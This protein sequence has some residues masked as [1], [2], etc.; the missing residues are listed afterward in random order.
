[1]NV[2]DTSDPACAAENASAV[3]ARIFATGNHMAS[4]PDDDQINRLAQLLDQRALPF[5]GLNIESLDGYLS[6]MVLSPND[7]VI[8]EWQPPV[9]GRLPPRWD[10]DVERAQVDALLQDQWHLASLRAR[11]DG[12]ELPAYLSPLIWLPEDPHAIDDDTSGAKALDI[13][14]AWASGFFRGVQL[15]ESAWD[16]WLDGSEWINDIFLL[17]DQLASGEIL[18]LDLSGV[19]IPITYRQRLDIV[20]SLP[21]M[22]RNLHHH[23]IDALTARE[24][25]RRTPTPERNAP[26][27]CGS[28]H[29]YKKCCGM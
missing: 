20:A 2:P 1:M 7:I 24:P 22:L 12:D 29:K 15:R 4:I 25:L 17:L 13:G 18:D 11:F 10:N 16:A 5:N 8:E 28:G 9:W 14:R 6:A 26:C 3:Q 19:P 27:P 23:R 21:D